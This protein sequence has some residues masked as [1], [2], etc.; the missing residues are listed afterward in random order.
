MTVDTID[1]DELQRILGEA[2][3]EQKLIESDGLLHVGR[4]VL[5]KEL[6]VFDEEFYE[7]K[8]TF[9]SNRIKEDGIRYVVAPVS[10][11]HN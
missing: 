2:E 4:I 1:P 6:P 10:V 8:R 9:W 11:L 5:P 3:R 7:W